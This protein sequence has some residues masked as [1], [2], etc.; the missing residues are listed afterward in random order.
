LIYLGGPAGALA[1]VGKNTGILCISEA[2]RVSWEGEGG[3]GERR[4]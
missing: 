4:E 1:W 2:L 3:G